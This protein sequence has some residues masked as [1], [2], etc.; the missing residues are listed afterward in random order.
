MSQ[1]ASPEKQVGGKREKAKTEKKVVRKRENRCFA[2][3][4]TFSEQG[5]DG[6]KVSE[7]ENVR[8]QDLESKEISEYEIIRNNNINER[9]EGMIE[10]GLWSKE[11]VALL[12]NGYMLETK[13]KIV[14]ENEWFFHTFLYLEF[15]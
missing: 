9:L 4:K 7:P 11:E 3:V 12:K 8:K 1:D 14:I 10:S 6:K 13:S 15:D 5:S 2:D